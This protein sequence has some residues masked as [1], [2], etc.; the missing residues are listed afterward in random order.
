MPYLIEGTTEQLCKSF[1]LD[2]MIGTNSAFSEIKKDLYRHEFIG[3]SEQAEHHINVWNSSSQEQAQY[4]TQGDMFAGNLFFFLNPKSPNHPLIKENEDQDLYLQTIKKNVSSI[5]FAFVNDDNELCGLTVFFRRDDPS[6]WMIGLVKNTNLVPADRTMILLT[7]MDLKTKSVSP[8]LVSKAVNATKNQLFAQVGSSFLRG[9]LQ[10][11]I[12]PNDETI[13]P[14]CERIELLINHMEAFSTPE[15][16]ELINLEEIEPQLLFAENSSIDLIR[17]YQLKLS[18]DMLKECIGKSSNLKTE[19]EN[20][21]LT[22]NDK[23]N[24][25]LLQMTIALYEAKILQEKR[26]L[27]DQHIFSKISNDFIWTDIQIKIIPFLFKNNY[28]LKQ[29]QFISSN[30]SYSSSFYMLLNTDIK[31]PEFYE[32]VLKD[33]SQG[34]LFRLF[35]PQLQTIQSKADRTSLIEILYTGINQDLD[36]QARAIQSLSNPTLF[37][38]AKRLHERFICVKQLQHLGF[39]PDFLALG[40]SSQINRKGTFATYP[41]VAL[42]VEHCA[43]HLHTAGLKDFLLNECL[44]ASS[45]FAHEIVSLHFINDVQ[46]N[47]NLLE[48][49]VV[50]YNEEILS[51]KRDFLQ[52]QV[53]SRVT[54]DFIWND[55]QIK[56]MPFLVKK[57]YSPTQFQLILNDKIYYTAVEFLKERGL[58]QN[59]PVF[60]ENQDK[61]AQ[62]KYIYGLASENQRDLCL[63]FW[64]KSDLSLAEIKEIAQA[65]E[66]N[67]L[68][69]DALINLDKTKP[70]DMREIQKIALDPNKKDKKQMLIILN[71]FENQFEQF[72]LKKSK[73]KKLDFEA[74]EELVRSFEVLNDVN[75]HLYALGQ[76][77]LTD[78][79]AAEPYT[80]PYHLALEDNEKGQLFRLFLPLLSNVQN[81]SHRAALIQIVYIGIVNG[82]GSQGEA[83]K[84]ITDNALLKLAKEVH[85]R[86]ICVQQ[87]QSL[88]F[89]AEVIAFAAEQVNDKAER[90]RQVILSVEEQCEK[91]Q[92]RLRQSSPSEVTKNWQLADKQYRQTI[93]DIV[94]EGFQNPETKINVRNS[95][96]EAEQAILAIVDPEIKSWLHQILV[97]IGNI[98]I[99]ALSLGIANE[100]KFEKTGN[101]W[102]FT[103]TESGEKLRA[104]DEQ[105]LELIDIP[106]L[107][108]AS[109]LQR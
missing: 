61:L 45:Q 34:Q 59:V 35:L 107:D 31:K 24:K 69:A 79:P 70:Q 109:V 32:L 75:I 5:G 73:L 102:F 41:S 48:M 77:S 74:R 58:T 21:K 103:Q 76:L 37:E 15:W 14:K 56:L 30:E 52:E 47:K 39:K 20:I 9:F 108:E 55:A 105:V 82:I 80:E 36:S 23:I 97:V 71:H 64:A 88:D 78:R 27:L 83:L 68:L 1:G 19:I 40:A 43:P 62:L 17:K 13:D 81:I 42:I 101:Y 87:L 65:M 28:D 54:K 22:D 51:K 38:F 106:A 66:K 7:S 50:F 12:K 104:L 53:F 91:V 44:L 49:A 8:N 100:I 60:L 94:Y 18:P 10:N 6:Q 92:E 57:G 46:V 33:N 16:P 25:N 85:K 26:S 67:P 93:Y 99:T 72:N 4:Y 11:I 96:K 2:W 86:F 90:F 63:I 98:L 3:S 84:R 29:I 95:I 89:T